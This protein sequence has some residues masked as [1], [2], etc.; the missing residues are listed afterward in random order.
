MYPPLVGPFDHGDGKRLLNSTN[1]VRFVL[2]RFR[3][4]CVILCNTCRYK[5]AKHE[6]REGSVGSAKNEMCRCTRT[7]ATTKALLSVMHPKTAAP[8]HPTP[9]ASTVSTVTQSTASSIKAPIL[10]TEPA[11]TDAP[12][13]APCLGG[14]LLQFSPPTAKTKGLNKKKNR[15]AAYEGEAAAAGECSKAC[16]DTAECRGFAVL[17]RRALQVKCELYRDVTENSLKG[18][19]SQWSLYVNPYFATLSWAECVHD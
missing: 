11:A 12:T 7:A 5:F 17:I 3:L 14:D 16:L 4:C 15:L 2:I 1:Y 9:S 19:N 8:T 6:A 10:K 18:A 13:L